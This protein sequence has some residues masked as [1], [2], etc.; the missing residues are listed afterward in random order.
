MA[1]NSDK[2]GK[3][4]RK[5]SGAKAEGG[6]LL[7]RQRSDPRSERRYEGKASAAAVV[8]MV[9]G[10]LAAVALGAGAFGQWLRPEEAGPH[11][12]ALYLLGAGVALAV[13]VAVFGQWGARPV[14]V[15]DAGVAVEKGPGEIER[16]A[17]RDVTAVTLSAGVLTFRASGAAIAIPVGAHPDAAARALAEARQRIPARVEAIPETSLPPPEATVASGQVI[18]LEPPQ[19]AGLH[20]AASEKLITFERDARLCGRCGEVYHKDGVPRRC[21]TCDAPLKA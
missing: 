4:K 13:A 1:E 2:P 20:C 3:R 16:V 17:W 15:G 12:Y 10:S 9:V 5:T 14:R 21:V 8:T 11:P 19:V 18:A 7:L 6:E